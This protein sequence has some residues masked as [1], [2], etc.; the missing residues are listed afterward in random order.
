MLEGENFAAFGQQGKDDG[1][2]VANRRKTHGY[3]RD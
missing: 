3:E 2:Y 1:D